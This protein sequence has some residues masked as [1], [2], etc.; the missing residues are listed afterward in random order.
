MTKKITVLLDLD[1][2]TG[3]I[4]GCK[5]AVDQYGVI[6]ASWSLQ[7]TDQA[8][9]DQLVQAVV[10]MLPTDGP[11]CLEVFD[12][13]SRTLQASL[14]KRLDIERDRTTTLRTRRA[15]VDAALDTLKDH[16]GSLVGVTRDQV[17]AVMEQMAADGKISL[18]GPT[19]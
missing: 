18:T 10:D 8:A 19:A 4:A 1:E 16:N 14:D 7:A 11:A 13:L 15:E 3:E 5:L 2:Q 12:R 17:V 9:G 6:S